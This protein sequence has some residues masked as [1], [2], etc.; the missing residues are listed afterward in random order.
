MTIPDVNGDPQDGSVSPPILAIGNDGAVLDRAEFE[1]IWQLTEHRGV[2][3]MTD[4]CYCHFLY[5][6]E[7]FSIASLA[8]AKDNVLV[9][10][11]LSKTYSMTG[12]RLGWLTHPAS[13][14]DQVAKLVQINTS[15]VPAFLQR[16]AIAALEKGDDFVAAM[17]ERCRAGGELVFQRLSGLP[18][19][20]ISRPEAG[21]PS[22]EK[23][24]L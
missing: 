13:L 23:R 3:L 21:E 16:G 6:S 9:A 8:G 11:S 24:T 15:G 22:F 1:K 4:E 18:R 12:W 19:V 17:V 10:G 7:P 14:G 20:T 2:Y 5:D